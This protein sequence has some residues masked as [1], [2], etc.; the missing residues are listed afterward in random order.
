M[1]KKYQPTDMW[2]NPIK[3]RRMEK[4][5]AFL[6]SLLFFWLAWSMVIGVLVQ[7]R[8]VFGWDVSFLP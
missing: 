6:L 1:S 4:V 8:W 5:K 3:P 7:L 2:G